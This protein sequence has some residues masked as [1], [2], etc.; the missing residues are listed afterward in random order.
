MRAKSR[1][2]AFFIFDDQCDPTNCTSTSLVPAQPTLGT[3]DLEEAALSPNTAASARDCPSE[4]SA[5]PVTGGG[6][7]ARARRQL[8]PQQPPIRTLPTAAEG[9]AAGGGGQ[10]TMC[11]PLQ[12]YVRLTTAA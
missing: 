1:R 11:P 3:C 10:A 9:G 8:L 7:A 2:D 4:E 5:R 6:E 12:N